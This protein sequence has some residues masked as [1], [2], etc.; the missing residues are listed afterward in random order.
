LVA[1]EVRKE[2]RRCRAESCWLDNWEA[3]VKEGLPDFA[4]E[5]KRKSPPTIAIRRKSRMSAST[6]QNSPHLLPVD[7]IGAS[8][9]DKGILSV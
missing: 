6:S 9:I 1:S 5:K 4:R 7:R 8:F 2:R 3:G